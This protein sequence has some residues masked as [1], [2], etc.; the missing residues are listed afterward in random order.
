MLLLKVRILQPRQSRRPWFTLRQPG[1]PSTAGPPDRWS[2]ISAAGFAPV[3][4]GGLDQAI[5]IEVFGDHPYRGRSAADQDGL[6]GLRA[7]RP[8]SWDPWAVIRICLAPAVPAGLGGLLHLAVAGR[9]EA[10][11]S[12]RELPQRPLRHCRAE[13]ALQLVIEDL[14]GLGEHTPALRRQLQ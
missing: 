13:P 14:P 2:L 1:A 11:E 9:P 10:G 12:S 6:P 7:S 5:R 4:A 8:T 3:K